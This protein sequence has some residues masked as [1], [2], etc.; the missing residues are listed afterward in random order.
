MA[1]KYPTSSPSSMKVEEL[2]PVTATALKNSAADVLDQVVAHGA[3]T[4]TRHDKPRAV[5]LSIEEYERLT[6]GEE[7]DWLAEMHKEYQGMLEKMQEPAQKE[8]A[9]RLFAATP[10]ELGEA[11][12]RGA[13]RKNNYKT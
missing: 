13:Q 8:A 12:V 6:A 1:K 5:M 7:G 3:I 10:E 11:A 4:I 2:P 9:K